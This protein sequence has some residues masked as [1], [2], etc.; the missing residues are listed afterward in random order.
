MALASV[1][2]PGVDRQS[3]VGDRLVD[4]CRQVAHMSH[5]ARLL[6]SVASDAIEDGVHATRRAIKSARRR[7]SDNLTDI[8]DEAIHC[9]K[10]RP[11]Q[12]VGTA[13]GAGLALGAAAVWIAGRCGRRG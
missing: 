7:V 2:I 5:E 11:V 9:V 6:E 3:T 10:R 8:K 13:F 12:A 4:A 1:E